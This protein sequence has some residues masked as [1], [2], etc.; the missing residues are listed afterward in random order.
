MALIDFVHKPL[1]L[2]RILTGVKHQRG[3]KKGA[4]NL[5]VFNPVM[6][7]DSTTPTPNI[8]VDK[9]QPVQVD[10]FHDRKHKSSYITCVSFYFQEKFF[11]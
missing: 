2:I 9:N 4:Q 1:F 5:R 10:A 11:L 6:C 3:V 8:F 7:L